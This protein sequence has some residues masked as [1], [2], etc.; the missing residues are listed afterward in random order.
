MPKRC[1]ASYAVRLLEGQK[2][3]QKGKNNTI[4]FIFFLIIQTNSQIHYYS[5][6]G[7][8]IDQNNGLILSHINQLSNIGSCDI[9]STKD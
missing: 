1:V 3:T 4:N 5:M 8:E 2:H 6:V 7:V 9:D